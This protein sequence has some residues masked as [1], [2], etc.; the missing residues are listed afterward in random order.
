MAVG[1]SDE[2]TSFDQRAVIKVCGIG[3]GG[4]NAVGRMIEAG[5]QDVEF[6]TINTDAQALKNSPAGTRLQIGA[7]ITSGLGSGAKPAVGKQAVMKPF[8]DELAPDE[9]S[10]LVAYLR[11]FEPPRL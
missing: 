4:G 7:Q 5:L 6:I 11:A 9:I 1:I 8:A 2:L 3:G 10:D